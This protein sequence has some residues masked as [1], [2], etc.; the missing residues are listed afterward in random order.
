MER[1]CG[2]E[3]VNIRI[4]IKHL[5]RIRSGFTVQSQNDNN[6]VWS[7]FRIRI[8]MVNL[9][10]CESMRIRTLNHFSIY[11]VRYLGERQ[12]RGRVLGSIL[13]LAVA[14]RFHDTRCCTEAKQQQNILVDL[15][16]YN[17]L[18]ESTAFYSC[19]CKGLELFY[20]YTGLRSCTQHMGSMEQPV[21]FW[22]CDVFSSRVCWFFT[23]GSADFSGIYPA[24]AMPMTPKISGGFATL[25]EVM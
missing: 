3:I 6:Y 16:C 20:R 10:Y 19:T 8:Q 12:W 15:L 22:P 21:V 13:V 9:L 14:P 24:W 5:K 23:S 11:A 1:G 18:A 17:T 25:P 7:R 2:Y 4:Q